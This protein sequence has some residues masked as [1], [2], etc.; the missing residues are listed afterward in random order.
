MRVLGEGRRDRAHR[1]RLRVDELGGAVLLRRQHRGAIGHLAVCQRRP[2]LDREHA[3]AG[4]L[5]PVLLDE[6][7]GVGEDDLRLR[8]YGADR[9]EHRV[10]A[11]LLGA[12]DLVDDAHVRQAQVR[13]AR[14]VAQLVTRPVRVDD[15]D[16]H[17]RPD[18]RRVVVAAVPDDDVGLLLGGRE[19]RGVVDAGEDEV[20]LGEVRLVLLALLDRAVGRVEVLVAREALDDLLRE[21]AVRHRVAEDGDALAVVAQE[22][23]HAPRRL[24]LPGAGAH[25]ADRND[26]LRR[27]ERSVVRREQPEVCAGRE[28]LR[29]HVHHVL[30]RHVG[31]G[32]DD[33]VDVV[34]TDQVGEL[35]LRV[36]RDPFRIE[37]AGEERGIDAARDVGDLRR[38]E[39]DDLVRPPGRDRRR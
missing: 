30:V 17:V 8:V 7:G 2:V 15:G 32:E 10:D 25:G 26:G 38:G 34:L 36:D 6:D 12:V 9:L 4:D 31:V 28:R 27:G 33:L 37:V 24:A 21:V 14:V 35:G 29:G 22:L 11:A 16:V 13:L 18:E 1:E 39:R 3:L 23:G 5:G 19:D 20:A